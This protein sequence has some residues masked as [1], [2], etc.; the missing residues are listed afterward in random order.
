MRPPCVRSF[1]AANGVVRLNS[2]VPLG[3]ASLLV[4]IFREQ[5]GYLAAVDGWGTVRLPT[6]S[7]IR[8][9]VKRLIRGTADEAYPTRIPQSARDGIA[10]LS[11]R[12]KLEA[13]RL[14]EPM[15]L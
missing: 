9:E 2:G 6:L 15:S 12:P 13:V 7:R 11:M 5:C 10:I 3:M 1:V 14:A 8:E 4:R